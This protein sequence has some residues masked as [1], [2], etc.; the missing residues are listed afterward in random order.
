MNY[1]IKL[2]LIPKHEP[3]TTSN[4][5]IERVDDSNMFKKMQIGYEL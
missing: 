3:F 5:L 1:L 4:V 2:T